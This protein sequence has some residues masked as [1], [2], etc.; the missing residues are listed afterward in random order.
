M[1]KLQYT[2]SKSSIEQP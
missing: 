1:Q 2:V